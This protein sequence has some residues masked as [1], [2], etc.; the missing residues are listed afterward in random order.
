MISQT[1]K[2]PLFRLAR[3]YTL[4]ELIVAIGVFGIVVTLAAG[5]Y[6]VVL[7]ITR[8]AQAN[9]TAVD[10]F[11]FALEKMTRSI[12]SGTNY[13]VLG[14]SF[15]FTN[16]A[17][18]SVTYERSGSVIEETKDGKTNTLT[19]PSIVIDHLDF[20]LFGSERGG[21]DGQPRVT[22]TISGS[23]EAGPGETLPFE[24]QTGATMR[25]I[26]L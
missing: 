9:A 10:N 23:I 22:I 19:D 26:D 5:A 6:F 4:I 13:A 17:G 14:D 15:S 11:S 16:A 1:H 12:R 8:Q 7:G 2:P 25:G 24:I 20:R 21:A 18:D 3:G